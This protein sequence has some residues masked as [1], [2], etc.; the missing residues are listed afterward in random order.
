M[1]QVLREG[2]AALG[3]AALLLAVVLAATPRIAFNDGLGHD[4]RQYAA[5]VLSLR[6]AAPPE[7]AVVSSLAAYR[8]APVAVV[9]WSGLA[10]G[11][12]FLALDLAAA[13]AGA[14]LLYAL[15]RRYGASVPLSLLGIVWWA[16]LPTGVR[17]F[18]YNPVLVDAAGFAALVA[19]LLAATSGRV[20]LF[21]ALL[22]L[23][24]LTREAVLLAVPFLW[25][26]LRR[27]GE[28]KAALVALLAAIPGLV[29]FAWVRA[30]PPVPPTDVVEPVSY[31]LLHLLLLAEPT[32]LWRYLAAIP[33]AL[34]LLTVV[35]LLAPRESWRFLREHPA[36]A[37]YG[38]AVLVLAPLSGR[39]Y[40][41]YLLWLAPVLLVLA[42]SVAAR[43]GLW[44]RWLVWP[45]LTVLHLVAVRFLWPVGVDERSYLEYFAG[46][47][48]LDR[49]ASLVAV[50]AAC[51]VAAV[52]TVAFARGR[53]S[54][55]AAS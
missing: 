44:D 45:A 53:W 41:R 20:P 16:A 54:W 2:A 22:P 40:D 3:L 31:V 55:S 9:A 19:L 38:L 12:A 25:L 43:S 11:I 10:P 13:L 49:L 52:V 28:R 46:Q 50:A 47:M 34:G 7:P 48:A 42:F 17:F 1:R 26:E 35:P 30:A 24:V 14:L 27:R 32:N 21:A 5:M 8:I 6:G 29:A 36:W 23:S 39:D 51:A 33:L 15:L 4:G 37:Y 18:V